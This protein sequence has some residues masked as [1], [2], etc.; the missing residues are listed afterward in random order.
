MSLL[1]VSVYSQT[2]RIKGLRVG[3]DLSRLSFYISEPERKSFEVSADVETLNNLY[4]T[5]E[6]GQERVAE[7][8]KPNNSQYDYSSQG[9]YYRLGADYNFLKIKGSSQYDML[10]LGLRYGFAKM[11]HSANNISVVNGY[12]GDFSGGEVPKNKINA[13]WSEA[14]FGIRAELFK[15]FFMGWSLRGRIM[16]SKTHDDQMD[17]YNIPGFGKGNKWS[18]FGFNYS[19]YYKIPIWKEKL[20][21][22]KEKPKK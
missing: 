19:I 13:Y 6:Y 3:Y 10:F 7:T 14:V 5:I 2:E 16:I 8:F 20:K 15:I 22:A 11:Y 17:A 4:P 21:P 12:W 9:Y 18:G 1:I